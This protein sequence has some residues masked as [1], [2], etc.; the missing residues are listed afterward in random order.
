MCQGDCDRDGR[1]TVAELT[2]AVNIALGRLSIE[3]CAAADADRNGAISIAELIAAV[4][5]ALEGCSDG[6]F[7]QFAG[8][9][10]VTT[11]PTEKF[12]QQMTGVA[13]VDPSNGELT[14]SISFGFSNS[15][16][17]QGPL[18]NDGHAQLEGNRVSG[19]I[20]FSVLGDAQLSRTAG[21]LSIEGALEDQFFPNPAPRLTFTMERPAAGQAAFETELLFA[22]EREDGSDNFAVVALTLPSSGLG[23]CGATNLT[24]APGGTTVASLAAATCLISP[25][26]QFVLRTNYDEPGAPFPEGIAFFAD[27][28]AAGSL[29]FGEGTFFKGAFPGPVERGDWSVRSSP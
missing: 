13:T 2:R 7:A 21:V 24:T 26:G 17:V 4:R 10:D 14:I 28:E 22:L 18:R 27:L 19:D 25:R 1:V 15:V 3:V 16:V 8:V 12:P 9:F 20:V 5:R 29:V 23:S 6:E 11:E